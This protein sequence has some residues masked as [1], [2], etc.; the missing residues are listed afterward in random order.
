[1]VAYNFQAQFASDVEAG[2]KRQTIR[3][4][5]KRKHAQPGDKLQLYTGMR[6]KSCR[7]LKDAVC[8]ESCPVT[9]EEDKV[10]TFSPT[11]L[12]TDLEGFAKQDGF[13]SWAMMRDWF[14]K[15]HGLPFEGTMIKWTFPLCDCPDPKQ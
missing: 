5:R 13:S 7:K 12:N 1:M 2:V 4:N 6:T 9:I 10:W 11:E 14:A 15:I 3:A 8:C